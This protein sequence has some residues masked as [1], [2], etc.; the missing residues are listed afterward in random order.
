VH[1]LGD[2]ILTAFWCLALNPPPSAA[3]ICLAYTA[4]PARGSCLFLS[5]GALAPLG[6]IRRLATSSK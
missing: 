6:R 3:A 1:I 5:H 4:L 2:F